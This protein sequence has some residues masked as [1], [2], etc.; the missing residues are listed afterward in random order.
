MRGRKKKEERRNK[1]EMVVYLPPVATVL[2]RLRQSSPVLRHPL[3]KAFYSG[4][5]GAVYQ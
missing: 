5:T 3:Y 2:S 4:S 1:M